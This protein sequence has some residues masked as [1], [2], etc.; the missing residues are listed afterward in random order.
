MGALEQVEQLLEQLNPAE[1]VLLLKKLVED[2]SDSHPGI[3]HTLGVCGGDA[4]ITRTRIPVWVLE[5]A[6]QDGLREADILH[7][8]PTL[9]AE[10][11][12]NA[13]SYVRNHRQEIENNISENE[14]D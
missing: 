10:D 6:R 7:A 11:L 3:E 8:Y 2:M 14:A 12:S 4:R 9:R 5:K 1:R 13:W